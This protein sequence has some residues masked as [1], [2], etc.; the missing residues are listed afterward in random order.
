MFGVWRG[1]RGDIEG[2]FKEHVQEKHR[3]IPQPFTSTRARSNP[4]RRLP[5]VRFA[6][7]PSWAV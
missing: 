1:L 2:C 7:I 5:N 3:T 4:E 6:E